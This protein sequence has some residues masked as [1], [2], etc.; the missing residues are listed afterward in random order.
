[1]KKGSVSVE[2]YRRRHN[3]IRYN[4]LK[5]NSIRLKSLK[6]TCLNSKIT[7]I[8]IRAKKS[9]TKNE[10]KYITKNLLLDSPYSNKKVY[11]EK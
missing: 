6:K 9:G 10:K 11:K 7:P 4:H 2:K 3:K 5:E 1:M 8:G